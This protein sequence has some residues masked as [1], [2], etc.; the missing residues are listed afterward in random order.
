MS[1]KTGIGTIFQKKVGAVYENISD[2]ISIAGPG[3]S[4]DSADS[5]TLDVDDG[6]REFIT[7][8]RDGGTL[9]FDMLF[10]RTGYESMLDDFNNDAPQDYGLFFAKQG[11]GAIQFKGLVTD[12]PLDI[13]LNDAITCSVSIKV[14]GGITIP[15]DGPYLVT[16][17]PNGA[18]GGVVPNPQTKL[19]AVSLPLRTNSGLLKLTGK[20]FNGWNTK[21]DGTGTHH[22]VGVVYT[23]NAPYVLY[24]EWTA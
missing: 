16:Y 6:F 9:S 24:A 7:G 8:L 21:A 11:E 12:L 22:N 4:R 15:D 2:L 1:G 19:H 17:L 10:T 13:P 14:T 20:T 23:G 3:T 5:T 18:T